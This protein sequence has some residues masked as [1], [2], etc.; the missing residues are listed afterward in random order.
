MQENVGGGDRW[1]RVV[2]GS[3][4]ASA[5]LY[6]IGKRPLA[7]ALLLSGAALV[8]ESAW[9]RVCPVNTLLG[10]DTRSQREIEITESR[11]PP[12]VMAFSTPSE[13]SN[14]S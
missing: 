6:F 11:R 14:S 9:T 5:G 12:P 1:T 3:G 10:V 13:L 4:L 8:L 7:P 2:I